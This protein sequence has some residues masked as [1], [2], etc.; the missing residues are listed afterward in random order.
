MMTATKSSE[1]DYF[2]ASDRQGVVSLADIFRAMHTI[3][4]WD[5]KK[6]RPD[7]L[8]VH[9]DD[10]AMLDVTPEVLV[11]AMEQARVHVVT[12]VAQPRGRVSVLDSRYYFGRTPRDGSRVNIHA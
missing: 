12:V 3:A 5:G 1:R 8:Y 6:M 4:N 2:L 7:T 10:Y 11:W 9:R